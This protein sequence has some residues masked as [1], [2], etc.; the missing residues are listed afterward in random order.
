[1]KVEL[2]REPIESEVP[3][4]NQYIIS[5]K[6]VDN[7]I[8][9]EYKT[10]T[11]RQIVFIT[12]PTGSGKTHFILYTL[13]SYIIEQKGRLLY[14][15]NRKVLKM[16]LEEELKNKVEWEMRNR[17]DN[18]SLKIEDYIR[19]MTYQSIEKSI[20]SNS[21]KDIIEFLKLFNWVVYD[22]CHYFYMDSDFNTNTE[23]SY[24]CLR[25]EFIGKRQI[26]MSATMDKIKKFILNRKPTLL[27]RLESGLETVMHMASVKEYTIPF[28]YDYINL[29][30]LKN[31]DHLIEHIEA[32]N[33]SSGMK[34]LIFVDKKDLG[35]ELK[36]RLISQQTKTQNND[37]EDMGK[38]T[39]CDKDVVFVDADYAKDQQAENAVNNITRQSY[40]NEKIIISTSVMDNGISFQDRDLRNIVICADTQETFIQM[41][42]ENGKTGRMYSYTYL[43]EMWNILKSVKIMS[44]GF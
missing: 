36:E 29:H 34:W 22:E 41:L 23:V 32:S 40:S 27:P 3:I 39:L 28:N 9:N 43:K 25:R 5:K 38:N 24:D 37:I 30:V 14:L 26:F 15:V 17:F 4:E 11:D 35:L 16:Q 13:L 44:N 31:I 42:G 1:M 20:K 10:W 12:S 18:V 6:Y 19:V 7:E 33:G 2:V 8:G 21:S